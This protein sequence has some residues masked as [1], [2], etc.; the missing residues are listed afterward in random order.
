[1]RRL[2]APTR[3]QFKEFVERSEPV[4]VENFAPVL[5]WSWEALLK[6]AKT[7]DVVQG[8]V[9]LSASGV[10]PDYH[11]P[12][13][14]DVAGAPKASR[15]EL[16]RKESMQLSEVLSRVVQS[17]GRLLTSEEGCSSSVVRA[18]ALY[19][20]ARLSASSVA[21][22][23]GFCS[24]L[25]CN[26]NDPEGP[27]LEVNDEGPTLEG[28]DEGPTLEVNDEGKLAPIT[29]DLQFNGEKIYS[30]GGG[31]MLK[32]DW[33]RE[34]ADAARPRF[35]LSQDFALGRANIAA[36]CLCWVSSEGCLTP[37]HYDLSDGILAQ[38][39][40]EKRVWLYDS[41]DHG[42]V[43]L[44]GVH[45]P[46]IDNWERQSYAELHGARK[47]AFPHLAQV[48]QWVADLKP[49]ELLFIPSNWLHEVHTRTPSFSLGWRFSMVRDQ[50]EGLTERSA[51]QQLERMAMEVRS[52][53]RSVESTLMEAL[54]DPKMVQMMASMMPSLL[55]QQSK[56]HPTISE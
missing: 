36:D 41:A 45:V 21:G 1:V 8:E 37:L 44:R 31:W 29:H 38:V 4:V 11:R 10:F 35:L 46:G 47:A 25:A 42:H 13:A 30:Y 5:E 28:N 19:K 33:L 3:E 7:S 16:M 43:Y 23:N 24:A 54:A 2:E 56:R 15:I 53:S 40:G 48:T 18:G 9:L 50:G 26:A 32:A 20:A 6:D 22:D 52:G 55:Q 12:D 34:R 49:G 39:L 51:G 27:T 17:P 14:G